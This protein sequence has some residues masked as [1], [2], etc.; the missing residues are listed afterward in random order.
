MHVLNPLMYWVSSI[1]QAIAPLRNALA[2]V[3]FLLYMR[4]VFSFTHVM[5]GTFDSGLVRHYRH[6]CLLRG[7]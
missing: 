6:Q 1:L 2:G 5:V 3:L 4:C 7:Q